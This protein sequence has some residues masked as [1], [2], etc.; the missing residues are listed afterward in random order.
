MTKKEFE[1]FKVIGK[2]GFKTTYITLSM[3]GLKFFDSTHEHLIRMSAEGRD[4]WIGLYGIITPIG[5][6]VNFTYKNKD[7][8]IDRKFIK[9]IYYFNK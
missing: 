2:D 9:H 8:S 4:F 6:K 1:R 7:Y 3:G 5:D